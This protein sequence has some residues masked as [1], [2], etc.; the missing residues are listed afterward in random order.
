[1]GVKKS[2]KRKAKAVSSHGKNEEEGKRLENAEP[3]DSY[4]GRKKKGAKRRK[5]S[6]A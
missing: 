3:V 5:T 2:Q 6:G 4:F 1:V